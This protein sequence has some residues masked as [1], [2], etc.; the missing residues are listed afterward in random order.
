MTPTS[1]QLWQRIHLAGLA[2]PDDCRN[3]AIEISHSAGLETLHNPSKLATELIRLGK[4]TSFQA[5]VIFGNQPIS[6]AIGPFRLVD[7]LES[8]LGPHWFL[9][10]DSSLPKQPPRWCYFLTS[11]DL[12]RPEFRNWPP[13]LDL[14]KKQ[15]AIHHP[16]IDKWIFSAIDRTCFVAFSEALEGQ[17]LTELL[18]HRTLNWTESTSMIEQLAAG[19]KKMH[20]SGVVHG[21]VCPDAIWC[22]DDG[23]FVLR[24]DS[25]FPPANAYSSIGNSI[26][27]SSSHEMM[28]VAAPELT[29]PNTT[30]SFQTDLYALGCIWYRSLTRCSPFGTIVPDTAQAWARAHTVDTFNSL[31]P[32]VLP[33]PLQRC[34]VHLVAKNPS[35]RF[36]S[37]SELIKAIEYAVDETERQHQVSTEFLVPPINKPADVPAVVVIEKQNP[38]K[39][40]ATQPGTKKSTKKSKKKKKPQWVLPAM[41]V[42]ACLVFGLAITLL[43]PKGP[44]IQ[45]TEPN[46]TSQSSGPAIANRDNVKTDSIE[47]TTAVTSKGNTTKVPTDTV[48]DHFAIASDDGQLLWAP[49][50]AG[51]PFS[52]E[53]FPAGLEAVAFVSGNVWHSRDSTQSIVKWWLASQPELAKLL[54]DIPLIS[55]DR[56]ESIAIALYPS[57]VPGVPQ[58]VFR[59]A[60]SQAV[61]VDSVIKTTQGFAL[62]MFDANNKER[63]GIWS[64]EAPSNAVAIVMDGMQ[65]DGASLVKRAVVGPHALLVTLPDLNGG[66]APLRRQLETLLK[67]TDSHSDLTLLF[68][69]SFLFGDCRELLL[70]GPKV[71]DVLRNAIDES[72]QAIAFTTT[73][74]SR[75]YMELRMLGSE[76]RDAGKFAASLKASLQQVPEEFER[77][78]ASGKTIHSYWR[79]LGLR[80]PQMMRTLNLL[81][82]FGLEDGQVVANVYLPIDAM[83][84]I[85]IATW[86]ALLNPMD[87]SG[88]GVVSVSI[89]SNKTPLKSMEEILESKI[90][91]GFEQESLEA[92]LQLISSEMSETILAGSPISITI[93]G[94]AFQKEGITR[95][96]SVRSFQHNGDS[97]RVI[98]TDLVRRANPVTTVQSPTERNQKVV[99][100]LLEDVAQPG[101]K[102]IELTTRA[103]SESNRVTLPKEFVPE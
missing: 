26:L 13:S 100:L 57:K 90:T 34:L 76:T 14:A 84:N 56:V 52:L 41:I 12:M 96:Q 20:D 11:Q 23:E 101:Q 1:V 65:T 70:R 35:S 36:A 16:S 89:P 67:A 42:G 94:A 8:Q 5:S 17:S 83:N 77:G 68:A 40:T 79:A 78:L 39:Q 37:A 25:I 21:C 82:R 4:I 54:S 33:N 93:N 47:P 19:L 72:M 61:A 43:V 92:A 49:P 85:V 71:H 87:E 97:L 15:M 9:A 29:L 3:W 50:H 10:I 63:R 6:L 38:N 31:D 51:S 2:S 7:S 58:S 102:R 69:P 30:L 80:Y 27:S 64:N 18:A 66:N 60:Y 55:D 73:I 24:R 45:P 46:S 81:G 32:R 86:M 91:I 48:N 59:I 53:M 74:E 44:T 98:L 28:S 88:S 22:V 99:W 95:N 103:W 75:W 62:K